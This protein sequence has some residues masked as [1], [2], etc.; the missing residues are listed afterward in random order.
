VQGSLDSWNRRL[1]GLV[2]PLKL[3]GGELYFRT[4]GD[5]CGELWQQKTD[6]GPQARWRAVQGDTT[7]DEPV[8]IG[9]IPTVL[10]VRFLG[11]VNGKH[12]CKP[13]SEVSPVATRQTKIS[14]GRRQRKNHAA[15][16]NN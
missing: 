11:P 15:V 7:R 16:P 3:Q 14:F 13:D 1:P 5:E 6:A 2:C 9:E 8:A 4:Q 10:A 12:H